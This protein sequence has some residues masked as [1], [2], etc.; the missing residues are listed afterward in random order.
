[1]II[2]LSLHSCFCLRLHVAQSRGEGATS[3]SFTSF[4]VSRKLN[5]MFV[6]WILGSSFQSG[7]SSFILSQSTNINFENR[8]PGTRVKLTQQVFIKNLLV[9]QAPWKVLG[10]RGESGMFYD[11]I[12]EPLSMADM[13]QV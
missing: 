7:T 13:R 5:E 1:M 3:F 10:W 9:I 12:D 4:S 8:L 2:H 11:L 6:G